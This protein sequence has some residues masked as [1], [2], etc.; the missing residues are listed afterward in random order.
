VAKG[1]VFSKLAGAGE[2]GYLYAQSL[3][4]TAGIGLGR[5]RGHAP[6]PPRSEREVDRRS[7]GCVDPV[8]GAVGL[9]VGGASDILVRADCVPRRMGPVYGR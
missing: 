3:C 8:Y 5:R 7:E 6:P 4:F 9:S 1:K 2:V